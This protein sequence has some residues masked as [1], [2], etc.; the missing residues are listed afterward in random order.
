MSHSIESLFKS[1][2][3]NCKVFQNGHII[4]NE[5]KNE[6]FENA[7]RD[8]VMRNCS[9][10]NQTASNQSTSSTANNQST[11]TTANNQSTKADAINNNQPMENHCA[12]SLKQ[13]CDELSTNNDCSNNKDNSACNDFDPTSLN[14]PALKQL[15]SLLVECL[16]HVNNNLSGCNYDYDEKNVVGVNLDEVDSNYGDDNNDDGENRECCVNQKNDINIK[17][18]CSVGTNNDQNISK[19]VLV[20]DTENND[21]NQDGGA[22]VLICRE[23][24]FFKE[25]CCESKDGS[26]CGLPCDCVLSCVLSCQKLDS[27]LTLKHIHNSYKVVC[28]Y[29]NTHHDSRQKCSIHGPY[30]AGW[31]HNCPLEEIKTEILDGLLVLKDNEEFHKKKTLKSG[32]KP[33]HQIRPEPDSAGFEKKPDFGRGRTSIKKFLTARSAKDCSII[34]S[35]SSSKS[36]KHLVKSCDNI[37]ILG[38]SK[39]IIANVSIIDLDM[40]DFHK[41][42]SY[43]EE[44]QTIVNCYESQ[45]CF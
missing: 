29:F 23:S 10:F 15:I 42:P 12:S 44:D 24:K 33:G 11:L 27:N 13:S 22:E 26:C 6:N 32:P 31:L 21:A 40:K 7:V 19:D 9:S 41:I 39:E 8:W 30:D 38:D 17:N 14:Q 18:C 5:F 20:Y 34:V 43:L 1:P 37:F 16:L 36:K 2:Q 4:L 28:D 35:L 3:N 25:P 45:Q